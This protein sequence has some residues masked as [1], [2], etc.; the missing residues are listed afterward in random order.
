MEPEPAEEKDNRSKHAQRNAVTRNCVG[1]AIFV[2]L[3][4]TRTDH[5]RAGKRHSSADHVD[6][7]GPS[8]IHR[9]IAQS[10]TSTQILEPTAAPDPAS[11]EGINEHADQIGRASCRERV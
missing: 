5:D 8:K 11:Y 3:A 6:H 4:N 9:A 1:R 2:E 7:A 10:Q